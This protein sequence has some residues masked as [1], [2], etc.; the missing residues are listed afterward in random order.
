MRLKKSLYHK[1]CYD[2]MKKTNKLHEVHNIYSLQRFFTC[3]FVL[4][5]CDLPAK[6]YFF[7]FEHILQYNGLLAIYLVF[8]CF[9]A[10]F[11][12]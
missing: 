12:L 10:S 2:T 3:F 7:L 5:C 11:L 4:K 8:C 1:K 9:I 6:V